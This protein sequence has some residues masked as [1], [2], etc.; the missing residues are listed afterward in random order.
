MLPPGPHHHHHHY[1]LA[2][3]RALKELKLQCMDI[4]AVRSLELI[5]RIMSIFLYVPVPITSCMP[6]NIAIIG[7]PVMTNLSWRFIS[8]Q[9]AIVYVLNYHFF[10]FIN[11]VLY[12]IQFR[13]L[14]SNEIYN[15]LREHVLVR[16][17]QN[18]EILRAPHRRM[19]S[20]RNRNIVFYTIS[21]LFVLLIIL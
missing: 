9:I 5:F 16:S 20:L 17:Q 4:M 13:C 3:F 18:E 12:N 11:E 6:A 1:H 15:N 21:I 19:I 2:Q 7:E 8:L 10:S 14:N